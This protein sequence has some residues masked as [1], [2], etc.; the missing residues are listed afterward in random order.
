MI[1]LFGGHLVVD[2]RFYSHTARTLRRGYGMSLHVDMPAALADAA[3]TDHRL[4]CM[5][6][7]ANARQPYGGHASAANTNVWGWWLV[8]VLHTS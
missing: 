3:T 6:Q 4:T 7:H 8:L 5:S 2:V 1:P